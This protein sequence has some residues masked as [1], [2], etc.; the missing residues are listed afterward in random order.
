[1]AGVTTAGALAGGGLPLGARAWLPV[2]L[3]TMHLSWGA[4]FLRGV[5]ES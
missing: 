1:A 5:R 3:A 2:V 4:G